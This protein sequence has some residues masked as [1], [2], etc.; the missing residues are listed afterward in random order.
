M[1]QSCTTLSPELLP[2]GIL[3][4]LL[5]FDAAAAGADLSPELQKRLDWNLDVM[6]NKST[7]T[8]RVPPTDFLLSL[9]LEYSDSFL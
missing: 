2:D 7:T 8:K 9:S 4:L 1:E 6:W 5:P 3:L